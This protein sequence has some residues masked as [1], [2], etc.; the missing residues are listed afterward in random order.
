[1][2]R[3]GYTP[4]YRH[5]SFQFGAASAA[6]GKVVQEVH[7]V[8]ADGISWEGLYTLEQQPGGSMKILG[9]VLAKASGQSI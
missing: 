9:C 1:M 6:D 7:I 4:L 5:K 8:D 3:K 2:A